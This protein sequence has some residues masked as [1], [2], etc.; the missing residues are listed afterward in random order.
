MSCFDHFSLCLVLHRFNPSGISVNFVD[1]HLVV[2][3]SAGGVRELSRLICVD[4]VPW[5]VDCNKNIFFII[6][7][8][9]DRV[10]LGKN[11]EFI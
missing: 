11:P 1:H 10:L 4:G 6:N 5:F 3:A 8:D 9:M 2:M 7:G